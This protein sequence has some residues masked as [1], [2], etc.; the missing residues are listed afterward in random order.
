MIKKIFLFSIL[1]LFL[2]AQGFAA[3]GVPDHV[4]RSI[5]SVYTFD[6]DRHNQ[7]AGDYVTVLND[8]SEWKIHPQDS[9]KYSQW[10]TGDIVHPRV[11]TSFYWFKREHKFELYN[12]TRN[13]SSRVML[14]SY[15]ANPLYVFDIQDIEV[16][17]KL[18]TKELKDKYG[19]IVLDSA[20][21]P[22]YEDQWVITYKTFVYLSD[23]T[24]W[25]ITTNKD[26]FKVGKFVY[27]GLN[28]NSDGFYYFFI[29]GS[30]R[31]ALWTKT[32]RVY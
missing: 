31:E 13:E 21:F 29:T 25:N 12:H 27:L 19:K 17:R 1:P 23:G 32:T 24:A 26:A 5:S 16:D 15:P 20:G 6:G 2:M 14:I 9:E 7:F 18:E 8:E 11:R 22:V 3:P 4:L 28:E 30:E 10:S